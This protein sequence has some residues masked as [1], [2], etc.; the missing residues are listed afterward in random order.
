DDGDYEVFFVAKGTPAE[1]AGFVKGDV[2][3]AI[4]GI[5]VASFSGLVAISE[6]FKAEAGTVY[7]IEVIRGGKPYQLKLKLEELL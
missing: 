2:V 1:R 3:T 6:L 7:A 5:P 4:N